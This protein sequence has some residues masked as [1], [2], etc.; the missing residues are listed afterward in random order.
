M[1]ERKVVKVAHPV[2]PGNDQGFCLMH[3]D[4]MTAEHVLYVDPATI[5]AEPD[6]T[7]TKRS[8]K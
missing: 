1:E 8:K 7:T 5:S 2:V 6:V 4:E 3:E